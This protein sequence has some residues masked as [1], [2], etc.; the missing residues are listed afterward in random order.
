MDRKTN[1]QK[2]KWADE[3]MNRNTDGQTDRKRHVDRCT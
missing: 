3:Q 1:E 2:D